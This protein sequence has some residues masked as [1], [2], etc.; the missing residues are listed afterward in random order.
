MSEWT[1]GWSHSLG[2]LIWFGFLICYWIGGRRHKWIRRWVG[3]LFLIG[4]VLVVALLKQQAEWA[5]LLL[6][7]ASVLALSL[8][9]GGNSL[10]QKVIRRL[11]YGVALGSLSLL[12]AIITGH[13]FLVALFQIM[14]AGFASVYF[15]ALNPLPS[16]V[17]E[18]IE[19]AALSTI[20]LPLMV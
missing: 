5:L 17:S 16:A 10:M 12:L 13:G 6:Y 11:R 1:L 14:L 20:C 9:Y 3:S 8:G 15:G 2:L 7:P 4:A 18:E 19:I